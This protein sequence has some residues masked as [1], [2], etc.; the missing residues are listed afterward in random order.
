MPAWARLLLQ[1]CTHSVNTPTT[2][3]THTYTHI[4]P[5]AWF[6]R[7]LCCHAVLPRLKAARC[8]P[9]SCATHAAIHSHTHT[10]THIHTDTDKCKQNSIHCLNLNQCQFWHLQRF[11]FAPFAYFCLA[12]NRGL[13]GRLRPVLTRPVPPV[14]MYVC[15]PL[16]SCMCMCV[17]VCVLCSQI[18]I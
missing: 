14:Y 12:K 3:H 6:R 4:V 8:Q 13:R 10:P 2:T 15:A 11:C 7:L 16:T 17:C 1:E 18:N 9:K 5:Y